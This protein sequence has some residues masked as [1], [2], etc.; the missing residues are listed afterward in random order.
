[1]S[2]SL[3]ISALA[4]ELGV[5]TRTI[6]FYEEQGLVEPERRGLERIYSANDHT[7]LVLVLRAKSLG[8]PLSECH[9]L[10]S[11]LRQSQ[12]HLDKNALIHRLEEIASLRERLEE[13]RSSIEHITQ[14]LE[15]AERSVYKRLDRMQRP[16]AEATGAR[17]QLDLG[18]LDDE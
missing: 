2:D 15:D 8:F 16:H 10:V 17:Y 13:Q 9:T 14:T 7:T 3:T 5:T 18:F 11:L 6:R 4:R 12:Q 1:M